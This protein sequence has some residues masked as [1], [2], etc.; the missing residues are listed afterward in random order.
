MPASVEQDEWKA[1]YVAYSTLVN[2]IDQ[3]CGGNPLPP[4]IDRSFL[5]N[6]SGSVQPL[7]LGT[8]KRAARHHR[9][10]SGELCP[11]QVLGQHA[12]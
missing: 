1:P 8:L 7:L 2:F 4:R 3:K 12:A 11:T 5:D 10:A 9:H 6:Y